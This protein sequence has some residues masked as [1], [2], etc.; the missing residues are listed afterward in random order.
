MERETE[1]RFVQCFVR[2]EKRERLLFELAG[3]KRREGIGRFCHGAEDLLMKEKI[4]ASGPLSLSA[5]QS[6]VQRCAKGQSAY[7]CAYNP[8]LDG[9]RVSG[10]EAVKGVLGNGMAAVIIFDSLVIV[11]TEQ[12]A[13][14]PKR[15]VLREKQ[16]KP[17][18]TCDLPCCTIVLHQKLPHRV[19]IPTKEDS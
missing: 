10:P 8:E 13:G 19:A 18:L 15:Y 5:V 17:R 2:R 1:R 3:K 6:L 9:L 11:E 16:R 7:V 4:I 12:A 14:T